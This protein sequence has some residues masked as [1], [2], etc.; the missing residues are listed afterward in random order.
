MEDYSQ[1]AW[2]YQ[3]LCHWKHNTDLPSISAVAANLFRAGNVPARFARFRYRIIADL[4]SMREWCDEAEWFQSNAFSPSWFESFHFVYQR[5]FQ[6]LKNVRVSWEHLLSNGDR[7]QEVSCLRKL[8]FSIQGILKTVVHRELEADSDIGC[9][10]RV[11]PKACVCGLKVWWDTS[12]GIY[13]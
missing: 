12:N 1:L 5:S 8:Q 9:R 10:T 4:A 2:L 3:G 7:H 6:G 11:V 13:S